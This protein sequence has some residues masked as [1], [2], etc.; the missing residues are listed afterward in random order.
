MIRSICI[1][2]VIGVF[3]LGASC[4]NNVY[5]SSIQGFETLEADIVH[6]FGNESYFTDFVITQNQEQE[7]EVSF[8]QTYAPNSFE[9]VGWAVVNGTWE[10]VSEVSLELGGGDIKDYMYS[11]T[12]EVNIIKMGYLA[13]LS[14]ERAKDKGLKNISLDQVSVISPDDGD[15]SKMGYVI[16]LSSPTQNI[17][18]LYNL[19]GDLIKKEIL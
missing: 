2:I 17:Q 18:F 13:N 5:P 15:K 6:K 1:A 11:M 19:K 4:N 10:K 7:L 16:K 14:I 8:L 9:M 3:A 12:N